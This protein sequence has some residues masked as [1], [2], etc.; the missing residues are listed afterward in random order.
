MGSFIGSFKLGAKYLSKEKESDKKKELLWEW[1]G[2]DDLILT[3]FKDEL[4]GDNFMDDKYTHS[5]GIDPDEFD[6]YWKS[7]KASFAS[8]PGIEAIYFETWDATEKVTAFYGMTNLR[9][10]KFTVL[11]S[12]RME[13][14]STTYNGWKGDLEDDPDT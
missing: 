3:P 14:T 2:D 5:I 11:A 9:Y 12:A 1:D 8:E 10:D 6:D 4:D 7:N 13:M